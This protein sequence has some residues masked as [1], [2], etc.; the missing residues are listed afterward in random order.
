[1][2]SIQNF[3]AVYTIV[4]FV[5]PGLIAAMVRAQFTTGRLPRATEAGLIYIALSTIYLA[6]AL[7]IFE[8]LPRDLGSMAATAEWLCLVFIGPALF[9]L[10]LGVG[11][12][13]GVARR[14]LL[15]LRLNP[16]HPMPTA[17][18]YKFTELVHRAGGGMGLGEAE[19]RYEVRGL[20]RR[21]IVHLLRAGRERHL[22]RRELRSVR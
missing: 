4:G 19:G 20:L 18:D 12:R 7:P 15:R 14:L 17:W 6:F 21:A 9:G 16:V 10:S 3:E 8:L 2:P 13:F 5:V 1:M 11:A 22:R